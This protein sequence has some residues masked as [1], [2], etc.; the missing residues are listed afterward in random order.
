MCKLHIPERTV[1][2]FMVGATFAALLFFTGPAFAGASPVGFWVGYVDGFLSLLKLVVSPFMDVTLVSAY[3]GRWTYSLGYYLGVL[4]FAGL[5]GAV[6]SVDNGYNVPLGNEPNRG[7]KRSD[8]AVIA[9][10]EPAATP[11]GH[12]IAEQRAT[13]RTM[14]DA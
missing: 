12:T 5:A 11:V 3:F 8:P 2:Y 1:K 14:V 7:G 6:A 10:V 9:G 13:A 4:T